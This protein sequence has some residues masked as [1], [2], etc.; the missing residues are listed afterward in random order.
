MKLCTI[1]AAKSTLFA[2]SRNNKHKDL[3]WQDY[4]K[5][6]V[7]LLCVIALLVW[8]LPRGSRSSFITDVGRPWPYGQFIAPFDFPVFKQWPALY[9]EQGP[10]HCYVNQRE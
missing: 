2:M 5:Q 10:I 3:S 4:L 9:H 8:A 6:V 7:V 1:F